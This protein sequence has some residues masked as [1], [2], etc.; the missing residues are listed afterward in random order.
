MSASKVLIKLPSFITKKGNNPVISMI[1]GGLSAVGLENTLAYSTDGIAW[2]GLGNS[3]FSSM[4]KAVAWNGKIWVAGG[5]GTSG[6]NTL[7]WSEDGNIWTGLGKSIISSFCNKVKW[8]G[9]IWV[10]LG[11][12]TNTL[13]WSPDG[14]N[15]NGLGNN[16]FKVVSYALAQKEVLP[17]EL[18]TEFL[19]NP[20]GLF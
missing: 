1:A 2:T 6:T 8:N 15:W 7:A 9:S 3:V 16:I 18:S 19:I 13:A 14:I 17:T 11:S 12:G 20:H 5:S 4:C 10:A